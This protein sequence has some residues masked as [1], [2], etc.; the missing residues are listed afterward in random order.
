MSIS[1]SMNVNGKAVTQACPAN[2]TLVDLLREKLQLTG[3]HVGCDTSQCGACTVHMN[4]R[5]IKACTILAAQC[6]GAE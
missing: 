6:E 1:V 2:T 4:G 3:T 5:A